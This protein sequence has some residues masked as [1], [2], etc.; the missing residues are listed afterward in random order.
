MAVGLV[1]LILICYGSLDLSMN[2]MNLEGKQ[3][4]QHMITPAPEKHSL[5]SNLSD[6]PFATEG[7]TEIVTNQKGPLHVEFSSVVNLDKLIEE[8]SVSP[9]GRFRPKE[10]VS[11]QKVAIIIPFR[12]RELHLKYWLYYMH[13]ILQRQQLDY[14][15]YVIEQTGADLFNRAKLFNVGYAE[16]LKEDNYDCFVFS[17][18]D[19]IPI[20]DRNI[21]KCYDQPRHLSVA[22]DKFNF[23][24]PYPQIFGGIS[25]L[26][27]QQLL[28]INGFSNNYWGWG[29]ED[30]D[31]YKRLSFR[32]MSISRPDLMIGRCKMIQHERDKLNP[33]N[34]K[35]MTQLSHTIQMM[36]KDGINSLSYSVV[37][38]EKS[39]LYTRISVNI[40]SPPAL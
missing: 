35:R 23:Q 21:Y 12:D 29:G 38:S 7:I 18:I 15:V 1:F 6:S 11:Q 36:D 37:S 8:G 25:A 19:I 39:S 13:P 4:Q 26:S 24:L 5:S 22:I 17:D 14:G 33:P 34:P 30:D 3:Q 27:K 32:G 28:K 31:I 10:C 2:F 40:G 9:G 20:D 16:A